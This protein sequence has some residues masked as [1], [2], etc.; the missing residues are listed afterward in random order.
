MEMNFPGTIMPSMWPEE[1]VHGN[2]QQYQQLWHL[3]G[4]HQ[5]VWGMEEDNSKFITPENSLLSYDSS[6]NSGNLKLDSL[7][8]HVY[9]VL[10]I[11]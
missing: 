4:L 2:R 6:A 3:E 11:F 9:H 10:T 8:K 5:P 1:Q 7:P